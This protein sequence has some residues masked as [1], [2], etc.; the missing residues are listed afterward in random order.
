LLTRC[1]WRRGIWTVGEQEDN[2]T[3]SP[4]CQWRS[5]P[6]DRYWAKGNP[7][8]TREPQ[9]LVGYRMIIAWSMMECRARDADT[10]EVRASVKV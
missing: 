5:R 6:K 4:E 2:R 8:W 1:H 9:G 7:L 3:V 10:R